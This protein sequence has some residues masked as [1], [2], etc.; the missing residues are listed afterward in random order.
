MVFLT[1]ADLL[2]GEDLEVTGVDFCNDD[3]EATVD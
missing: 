3:T 1:I 2:A